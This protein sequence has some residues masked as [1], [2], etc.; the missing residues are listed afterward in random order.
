MTFATRLYLVV[1]LL[2]LAT[3]GMS[4]CRSSE[5]S[6]GEARCEGSV[7]QSCQT[8]EDGNG[9]L[10]GHWVPV[11]DCAGRFCIVAN[12][13]AGQT[14]AFC[15][16][17][18]TPDDRCVDADLPVCDGAGLVSCT[19]GYATA[20][21]ACASGC[22]ALDDHA[23]HC[24]EDSAGDPLCAIDGSACEAVSDL[25]TVV[26]QAAPAPGGACAEAGCGS[27]TPAPTRIYAFR[28]QNHALVARTR[29]A[30]GCAFAA[31]C[32]THCM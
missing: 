32:S 18:P 24:A 2:A 12:G 17:A 25:G 16:L 11:A 5:C 7:A 20:E 9:G 27:T 14:H 8:D 30:S 6:R 31:D 26:C 19:A 28:C 13:T 15:A 29:C 21:T 23:D 4:G 22:L 1:A 10:I 3:A